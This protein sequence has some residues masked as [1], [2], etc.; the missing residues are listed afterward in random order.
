MS[1]EQVNISDLGLFDF[2][3]DWARKSAGVTLGRVEN[4]REDKPR[5]FGEKHDNRRPPRDKF[6][7][8]KPSRPDARTFDKRRND[9]GGAVRERI[10]PLEAEIKK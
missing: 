2:T 10:Q 5:Q 7:G 6:K 1:E 8:A 3:P 9:G 4:A